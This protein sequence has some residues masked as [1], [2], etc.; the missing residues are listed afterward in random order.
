MES[1]F[2]NDFTKIKDLP[3]CVLTDLFMATIAVKE[4]L[5]LTPCIRLLAL[6]HRTVVSDTLHMP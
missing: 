5:S 2:S 3:E 1:T 6:K 4:I